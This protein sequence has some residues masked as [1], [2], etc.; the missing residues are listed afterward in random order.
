MTNSADDPLASTSKSPL[1]ASL[2]LFCMF[3]SYIRPMKGLVIPSSKAL[4]TLRNTVLAA[5]SNI[6]RP[7]AVSCVPPTSPCAI[8]GK[9]VTSLA[10]FLAV[11]KILDSSA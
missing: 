8:I 4:T 1:I 6:L 10:M 9:L 2:S 7:A 3:Q 5:L 11:S